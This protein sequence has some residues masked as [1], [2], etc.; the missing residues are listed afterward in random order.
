VEV[1]VAGPTLKYSTAE[2]L[3][4]G[5]NINRW[6]LV[7]Y[8]DPGREAEISF[9]TQDQPQIDG[10]TTYIYWDRDFQSVVI[11]VRFDQ[12][13]K[14]LVV[15][16]NL[17][18]VLVPRER[19]LRT[20]VADFPIK[21]FSGAEGEKPVA[22]PFISDAALLVSSGAR[23]DHVWAD[24][25]FRP[26]S[27]ELTA[28]L[29]PKPSRCHVD[30]RKTELR[31][32]S[33][34]RTTRISLSTPEL[35]Y[36]PM[37]IKSVR[38]WVEKISGQQ[39]G[40][41]LKSRLLPLEDLGPVPYN[42][43]KYR[44]EPF[45]YSNQSKLFVSTFADDE[46]KVFINGKVVPE[47]SN[48]KTEVE[49]DLSKYVKQGSNTLEISYELFGS[50]NFGKNLGELKGVK[51]VGIGD[52]AQ[53]ATPL[54]NWQI[55]RFP[56]PSQGRGRINP[57]QSVGAWSDPVSIGTGGGKE[58][59]PVYTWC[60]AEFEME[61]PAEEW[62]A[63]WKV[64]FEAD[65]DALLYLNGKFVGRYVTVGP[66]KDFYL[67]E[68]FFIAE[69]G[70]KNI[71]TVVLAYTS[72]AGHIRTLRIAPYDEFVTRRTRVEFEW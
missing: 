55:Q 26:G 72:Q 38:T 30:G 67:P 23:R 22:V 31:Y 34:G 12:S 18:V 10:D 13:E 7:L 16:Q 25:E 17:I 51:S 71:L 44:T 2:V 33:K 50:P 14:T 56:A 21:D 61:Q 35:P 19:A 8:D 37:P 65:R 47:A 15:N 45:T 43:V 59:L 46:K 3:A 9:A 29:P 20:W 49:I 48:K 64:T 70:K 53:S 63:P 66:Q 58:V 11:G 52:N 42:Y 36:Q 62:F 28:M 4:H 6:F 1:P 60:S 57:E 32:E 54:G 5:L 39:A 68:P 40:E 27:H 69:K 24:L 41:W